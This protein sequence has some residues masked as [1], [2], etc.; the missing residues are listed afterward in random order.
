MLRWAL[1]PFVFP[2]AFQNAKACVIVRLEP[3]VAHGTVFSR[4][5]T[6]LEPDIWLRITTRSERCFHAESIAECH[7]IVHWPNE[8]G[9]N[10]SAGLAQTLAVHPRLDR[11]LFERE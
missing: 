6:R 7:K 1:P 3:G 4:R 8:A 5:L 10:L 11:V 9:H 2:V